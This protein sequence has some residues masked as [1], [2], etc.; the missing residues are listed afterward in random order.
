[1]DK[2]KINQLLAQLDGSGSDKEFDAVQEL[3]KL[4][5]RFPKILLEQYRISNKWSTRSSCVYHAFRYARNIEDAVQLGIEGLS[6]RSK[7][8]R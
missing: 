5:K 3:R 8:V 4:G 1:M 2:K 6:D 7:V